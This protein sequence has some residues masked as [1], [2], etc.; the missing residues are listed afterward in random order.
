MSI[1]RKWG[2]RRCNHAQ[3]PW[4]NHAVVHSRRAHTGYVHE[5]MRDDQHQR[6]RNSPVLP[7]LTR[8]VLPDRSDQPRSVCVLPL[9]R[10]IL[11]GG[12]GLQS[13][14]HVRLV[15][16]DTRRPVAAL[17]RHHAHAREYEQRSNRELD[18]IPLA[19]S[20]P[21]I[22]HARPC[23]T[24]AARPQNH[25]PISRRWFFHYSVQKNTDPN[26]SCDMFG[27]FVC[28][29]CGQDS[30]HHEWSSMYSHSFLKKTFL[31]IWASARASSGLANSPNCKARARQIASFTSGWSP[32]KL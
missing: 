10:A 7:S 22:S 24:R 29:A 3:G 2:Y 12:V 31:V 17:G 15:R 23:V 19:K 8:G 16:D 30:A 11:E 1:H 14:T 18:R 26:T 32:V 25:R 27:S 28:R 6:V 13:R 20:L 5:C 4:R 9:E 21:R